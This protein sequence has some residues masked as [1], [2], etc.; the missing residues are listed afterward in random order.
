MVSVGVE[1]TAVEARVCVVLIQSLF[2]SEVDLRVLPPQPVAIL[3]LPLPGHVYQLLKSHQRVTEISDRTD[4]TS[5]DSLQPKH[6]HTHT[7]GTN[8]RLD[9][10]PFLSAAAIA[11]LEKVG[12]VDSDAMVG[13][14]QRGK[15]VPGANRKFRGKG[16]DLAKKKRGGALKISLS[17]LEMIDHEIQTCYQS[18]DRDEQHR[19]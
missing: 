5:R 2:L 4:K 7:R 6:T 16:L 3:H 11:G 18:A 8:L 14:I 13:V 17:C 9:K 19:M 10:P 12:R 1:V 15:V